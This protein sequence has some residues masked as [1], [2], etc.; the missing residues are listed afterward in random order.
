MLKKKTIK[1]IALLLIFILVF[2][3]SCKNQ[4]TNFGKVNDSNNITQETTNNQNSSSNNDSSKEQDNSS[5]SSSEISV[6][7]E[8]PAG[9]EAVAHTNLPAHYIKDVAVFMLSNVGYIGANIDEVAE[10]AKKSN[11]AMYQNVT[12][13]GDTEKI[14][15]DGI[16]ARKFVCSYE[17]NKLPMKSMFIYFFKGEKT[18][19]ITF[20]TTQTNLDGYYDW[21]S[22]YIEDYESIL[23]NIKI[24]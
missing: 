14:K 1:R 11:E 6:E 19:S 22:N 9:W 3:C 5:D 2:L 23:A 18:Y 21:F 20:T 17:F 4:E 15:I 12:Y 16:D 7:V 8:M 13:D 24:K 10:I